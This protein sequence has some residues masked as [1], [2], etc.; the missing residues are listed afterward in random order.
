MTGGEVT[1][2][3]DIFELVRFAKECG[4]KSIQVQSNGRMFSYMDFCK[5]LIDA[6]ANEFGVSVHGSTP[7]IH[8][9]L[10]RVRGGFRQVYQGL[11]NLKELNQKICTNTAVTRTNYKDLNNITKMLIGFNV[12]EHDFTF[13]YLNLN[14]LRD[15]KLIE[16]IAPRYSE[17]KEY[18]EKCLGMGTEARMK[19]KTEAFPF[20]TLGED[21]HSFIKALCIPDNIVYE[22]GKI[23]DFR[24]EGVKSDIGKNKF[25]KCK[26]CKF[27][28]RCEGP[29]ISYGKIFGED[30]FEPI[31]E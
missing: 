31:K 9:S 16:E 30:E 3:K 8:D 5:K 24:G 21:Y 22:N 10:I 27:Y 2:R 29:W 13:L 11:S 25:E 15:K 23:F 4:Y 17:V 14:I 7:E 6:G 28:D 18:V 26:Q 1:I 19:I 12:F 20:C